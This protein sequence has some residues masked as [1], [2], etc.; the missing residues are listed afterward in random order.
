[1]EQVVLKP[2]ILPE[3]LRIAANDRPGKE[4]F[5]ISDLLAHPYMAD[6]LPKKILKAIRVGYREKDITVGE[7]TEQ[8]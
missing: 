5:T 8:E 1:M 6:P 2:D 7:S 4:D 3:Q